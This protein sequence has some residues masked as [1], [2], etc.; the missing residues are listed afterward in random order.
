MSGKSWESSGDASVD[1]AAAAEGRSSDG[2]KI[3]KLPPIDLPSTIMESPSKNVATKGARRTSFTDYEE[4]QTKMRQ[5]TMS[6]VDFL[7]SPV[8]GKKSLGGSSATVHPGASG[9]GGGG[10]G[11]G[12]G[13][14][15]ATAGDLAQ[16]EAPKR[17]LLMSPLRKGRSFH[18]EAAAARSDRRRS[19]VDGMSK[20]T[21]A[22]VQGGGRRKS[23]NGIFSFLFPSTRD[24]TP[25]S[26]APIK[27]VKEWERYQKIRAK[28]V[29]ASKGNSGGAVTAATSGFP[30]G[31]VDLKPIPDTLMTEWDATVERQR[32]GDR[33]PALDRLSMTVD[34]KYPFVGPEVLYLGCKVKFVMGL[35]T[36]GGGGDGG[37]GGA[38]AESGAATAAAAVPVGEVA[39]VDAA[40]SPGG[41]TVSDTERVFTV[42]WTPAQNLL[43]AMKTSIELV[44]QNQTMVEAMPTAVGSVAANP[45]PGIPV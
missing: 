3:A 32:D 28:N 38:D 20:A 35:G 18:D 31:I 6:N 4:M 25:R 22:I 34:E 5:T 10:G 14:G 36:G 8:A 27:L 44:R 42:V 40:M 19:S 21:K 12:R 39:R 37:G 2:R 7:A 23:R 26:R 15:E 41:T 9:G 33:R 24:V 13:G 1:G 29:K 45:N 43:D 17:K 11:G 16:P 30:A